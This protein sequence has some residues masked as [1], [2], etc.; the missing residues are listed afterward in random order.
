MMKFFIPVEVIQAI[1]PE[2]QLIKHRFSVKGAKKCSKSVSLSPA[3]QKLS[4]GEILEVWRKHDTHTV[5]T[6]LELF[7]VGATLPLATTPD[8]REDPDGRPVFRE[9]PLS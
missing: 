4:F 5:N 1:D 8:V 9:I 3:T 6:K 7:G 2:F